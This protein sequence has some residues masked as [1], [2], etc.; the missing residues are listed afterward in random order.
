MSYARMFSDDVY[1]YAHTSGGVVCAACYFC[2]EL[3][4]SYHAESTQEMIDH[5]KAHLRVGHSMP[6]TIFDELLADDAENYPN[7]KPSQNN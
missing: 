5:L 3:E 2:D 4:P 7:K 6:A 1:V